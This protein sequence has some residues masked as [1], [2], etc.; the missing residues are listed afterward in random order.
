MAREL[1]DFFE[2]CVGK[3]AT[4]LDKDILYL[5]IDNKGVIIHD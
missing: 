4:E 2:K 1:I 3:K 5:L